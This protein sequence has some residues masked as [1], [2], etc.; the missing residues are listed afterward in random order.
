[1]IRLNSLLNEAKTLNSKPPYV[2]WKFGKWD[3]LNKTELERAMSKVLKTP[4]KME[5]RTNEFSGIKL[6][7]FENSAGKLI[8]EEWE[9]ATGSYGWSRHKHYANGDEDIEGTHLDTVD[10]IGKEF[11]RYNFDKDWNYLKRIDKTG[12]HYFV[13]KKSG[14]PIK[15]SNNLLEPQSSNTDW[16][17]LRPGTKPYEAV[18]T[19]VFGDRGLPGVNYFPEKLKKGDPIQFNDNTHIGE[20]LNIYVYKNNKFESAGFYKI[21]S[22]YNIKYLGQSSDEKYVYVQFMLEPG[23]PKY[24][25]SKKFIQTN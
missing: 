3:K 10:H 19:K 17:E 5:V 23:K 25:I 15:F 18:K 4:V 14:K 7:S 9:S 13:V 2:T 11:Y 24:W 12:T 1:M 20:R 21:E 8:Y 6:L 16:V 22:N